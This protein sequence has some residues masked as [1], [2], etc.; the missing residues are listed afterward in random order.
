[1]TGTTPDSGARAGVVMV[2]FAGVF[3]SLQGVTI[4]FIDDAASSQ[5]VFWRAVSQCLTLLIIIAVINRG[6]V[7]H[8]FRTAGIAGICGGVCGLGAGTSFVF[9]L[10]HTTVATV[11]FIMAS[12]PLFAALLAWLIMRERLDR[13]TLVS[14]LVAMTGIGIMVSEGFAGGG[15]LGYAFSLACT[16]CFA[17]IAVVA[18]WGRGVSMMPGTWLGAFMTVP[19]AFWLSSGSVTIPLDE[20]GYSFISGGLLTAIGATL[21]L[22]GAKYVA[23]GVLAFLTLTE[24]VLAPIWV[25]WVFNEVPSGHTLAGGVVVLTALLIEGIR[26]ARSIGR[27]KA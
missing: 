18:R 27:N 22:L 11:M 7:V 15:L 5:V 13:A 19:F 9:A 16:I 12:S 4:R 24:I 3:W 1:L 6:R 23:A 17:G 14:M 25:L 8:A 10:H 26:Q 20:V 21:F 2:L